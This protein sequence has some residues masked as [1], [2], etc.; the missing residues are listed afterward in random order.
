MLKINSFTFNDFQENTYV[1]ENEAGDCWI[2]DPGMYRE[3]EVSALNAFMGKRALRPRA[4]IN[5]HCHLDH[6]FG[7]AALQ[8]KYGIPFGIHELEQTVLE[9]APASAAMFGIKMAGAPKF[10]FLIPDGTPLQLGNDVLDVLHCPGHSPGSIVFHFAAGG[11]AIGGDVLFSGSIGRTD[12]PG[13]DYDTL[14]RSIHEKMF[15]LPDETIVYSGHGP[16]TKIGVE[17][18]HNPYVGL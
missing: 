16:A 7:V 3:A 15:L 5:T 8:E 2:V 10:D 14:I 4:I 1:L 6:I 9:F 13:G 17:K 11:W 12:L 18:K